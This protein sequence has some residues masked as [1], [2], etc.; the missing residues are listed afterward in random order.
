MYYRIFTVEETGKHHTC[1]VKS[2]GSLDDAKAEYI[3]LRLVQSQ[4]GF[5]TPMPKEVTVEFN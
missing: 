3:A 1:T 4:K 5:K 2:N